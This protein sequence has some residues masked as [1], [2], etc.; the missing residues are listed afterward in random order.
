MKKSLLLLT[1]AL[2]CVALWAQ[3]EPR[4]FLISYQKDGQQMHE[5]MD[6]NDSL[7]LPKLKAIAAISE[8]KIEVISDSIQDMYD[9][10]GNLKIQRIS[11]YRR[12]SGQA[13]EVYTY[14]DRNHLVRK[15]C[16]D[17]HGELKDG[18]QGFAYQECMYDSEG[19]VVEKRFFD[20]REKPVSLEDSGPAIVHY[21]YD[22]QNR[23]MR[24]SYM[25]ERGHLLKDRLAM[26]RY[27]YND[28]DSDMEPVAKIQLDRDGNELHRLNLR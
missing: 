3:H 14:D 19:N 13:Y 25:D 1:Y 21:D 18:P 27:L 2:Q 22:A 28:T 16:Y 6:L 9:E 7:L 11:G 26:E 8:Y 5:V 15:A 24:V 20:E 10:R 23:L 4:E 17:V 12:L